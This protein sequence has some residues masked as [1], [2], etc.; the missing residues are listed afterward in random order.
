MNLQNLHNVVLCRSFMSFKFTL[1]V[2]DIGKES[3]TIKFRF[4]KFV[5]NL[6]IV[7]SSKTVI[8]D[9]ALFDTFVSKSCNLNFYLFLMCFEF[10]FI[11]RKGAEC[12]LR[13]YFL[14]RDFF[15]NN[16]LIFFQLKWFSR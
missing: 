11:C 2:L 1:F 8:M 6:I 3:K 15:N 5:V 13:F 10:S 4:H 16:L 14:V 12:Q 9:K 7:V